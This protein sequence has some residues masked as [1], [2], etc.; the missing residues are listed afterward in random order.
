MV[1]DRV[2]WTERRVSWSR[3]EANHAVL[4][5]ASNIERTCRRCFPSAA[6]YKTEL[7]NLR[8]L[9]D[10]VRVRIRRGSFCAIVSTHYFLDERPEADGWAIRMVTSAKQEPPSLPENVRFGRRLAIGMAITGVVTVLIAAFGASGL[11]GYFRLSLMMSFLIMMTPALAW[12]SSA[13]SEASGTL[14][15]QP[16]PALPPATDDFARWQ[17]TLAEMRAKEALFAD[18]RALPFRR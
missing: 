2:S 4:V 14:A 12:L 16:W 8:G 17:Q 11:W 10:G 6:G 7:T 15:A 3:E 1:E 9:V 18:H 13:K 5:L